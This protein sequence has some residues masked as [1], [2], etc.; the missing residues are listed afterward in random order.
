MGPWVLEP[1]LRVFILIIS[2]L[3]DGL[4]IILY[5]VYTITAKMIAVFC[6]EASC[7]LSIS[8]IPLKTFLLFLSVIKTLLIPHLECA[9]SSGAYACLS[10]SS[11]CSPVQLRSAP[12][13]SPKAAALQRRSCR[14]RAARK[15]EPVGL[16]APKVAA[17]MDVRG[18]APFKEQLLSF[19]L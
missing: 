7:I 16:R 15:Q 13:C 3:S 18:K 17:G 5:L 12:G 2:S 8:P 1:C 9:S 4:L 14:L 19:L 11:C 6:L 10:C